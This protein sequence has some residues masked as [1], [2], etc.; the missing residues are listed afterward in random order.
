M[1]AE[2]DGGSWT[3]REMEYG[4]PAA[5]R[6]QPG[7]ATIETQD[8]AQPRSLGIAYP[9]WPETPGQPHIGAKE[10]PEAADAPACAQLRRPK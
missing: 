7:S 10:S 2:G 1:R 6:V 4:S 8:S 5:L 3:Y 9:A